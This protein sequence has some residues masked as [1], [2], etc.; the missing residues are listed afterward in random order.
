MKDNKEQQ[1][2]SVEEAAKEYYFKH[3]GAKDNLENYLQLMV[4]FANELSQPVSA[5]LPKEEEPNQK[6]VKELERVM[7]E[8]SFRYYATMKK[9]D[10]S[11]WQPI[12]EA[13]ALLHNKDIYEG[14]PTIPVREP[15]KGEYWPKPKQSG[16][17]YEKGE[18]YD[19]FI[20]QLEKGEIDKGTCLEKIV[21]VSEQY[22]SDYAHYC[23]DKQK[24]KHRLEVEALIAKWEKVAELYKDMESEQSLVQA[25]NIQRDLREL[26]N[27]KQ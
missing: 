5:P 26:I 21:E 16:I 27:P 20:D 14:E 15:K 4:G 2:A 6:Y 3:T 7:S 12:E 17:L 13:I 9:C 23:V 10:P 25:R 24:E 1:S 11:I 8:I 19:V 18:T 22:A